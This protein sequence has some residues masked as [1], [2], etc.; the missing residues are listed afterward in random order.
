MSQLTV[1]S[2][3]PPEGILI[4]IVATLS[5]MSLGYLNLKLQTSFAGGRL[6]P[7]WGAELNSNNKRCPSL[8]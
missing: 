6:R 3:I 1:P 4:Y 7:Y 2:G 8:S 5:Y